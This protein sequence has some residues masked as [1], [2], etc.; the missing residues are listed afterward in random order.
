[1][2]K[3]MFYFVAGMVAP[4]II[5]WMWVRHPVQCAKEAYRSWQ[6]VFRGRDLE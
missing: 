4:F 6:L 3:W 2:N 5:V 1:M